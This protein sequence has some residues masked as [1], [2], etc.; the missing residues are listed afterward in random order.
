MSETKLSMLEV[1][2]LTI[3]LIVLIQIIVSIS[4]HLLKINSKYYPIKYSISIVSRFINHLMILFM[5]AI[6]PILS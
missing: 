4:F 3:N 1:D 5:S 6:H 2:F